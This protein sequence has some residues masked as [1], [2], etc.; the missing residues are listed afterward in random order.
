MTIT[1]SRRAVVA[2]ALAGGLAYVG[3]GRPGLRAQAPP[4][5]DAPAGL[6]AV[7]PIDAH[8]HAYAAPPAL[9][10]L[11]T[12]LHLRTLRSGARPPAG[13]PCAPRSI[14]TASSVRTSS[15]R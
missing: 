3:V 9:V 8:V 4:E 10:A 13:P 7:E 12:R 5:A 1:L 2:L 11:F 6:A 14:R 15:A